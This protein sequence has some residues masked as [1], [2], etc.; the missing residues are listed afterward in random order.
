M[1]TGGQLQLGCNNFEAS[2]L[3]KGTC[4]GCEDGTPI[5]DEGEIRDLAERELQASSRRA[6]LSSAAAPRRR[7]LKESETSYCDGKTIAKRAPT[8]EEFSDELLVALPDPMPDSSVPSICGLLVP[9]IF[10]ATTP[11]GDE[12][13]FTQAIALERKDG[14]SLAEADLVI[15][16]NG[17]RTACIQFDQAVTAV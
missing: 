5:L 4:R 8:L 7:R 11:D 16:E 3:V 14:G 10:C 17:L 2:F 12:I 9:E 1:S 15:L 13:S 6:H